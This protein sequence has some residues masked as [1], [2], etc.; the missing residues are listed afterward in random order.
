M[1]HTFALCNLA[2]FSGF[3]NI[4]ENV[5]NATK[6]IWLFFNAEIF[7]YYI[8]KKK[9]DPEEAFLRRRWQWQY[10]HRLCI[11]ILNY[12]FY[13]LHQDKRSIYAEPSPV[14]LNCCLTKLTAC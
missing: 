2:N 11:S 3:E 14:F 12:A 13:T 10:V 8:F 4:W 6:Y 1:K 9:K 7:T 5:H